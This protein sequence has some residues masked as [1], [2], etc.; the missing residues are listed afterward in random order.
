[1]REPFDN[2]EAAHRA[3]AVLSA[4]MYDNASEPDVKRMLNEYMG[5]D[6]A[7]QVLIGGFVSLCAAMLRYLSK[8]TDRAPD[9]LLQ[10]VS[11]WSG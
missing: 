5:S 4:A 9:E 10:E 3:V 1:M 8:E 6:E 11:G 2:D 7:R